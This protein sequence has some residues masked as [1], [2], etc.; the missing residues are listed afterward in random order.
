MLFT[1]IAFIFVAF[2]SKLLLA[3]AMCYLIFPAER[4]CDACN[5][6]TLAVRMG[7]GGRVLSRLLLGRLQRRWC[8]RCGW[9]GYTRTS[10]REPA[11]ALGSAPRP[12]AR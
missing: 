11:A 4:T 2:V 7:P 1:W 12:A 8:P 5:G 3:V 6:E 9:Q 10:D